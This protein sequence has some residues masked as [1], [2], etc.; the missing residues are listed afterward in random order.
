MA[1]RALPREESLTVLR[2]ADRRFGHGD[3]AEIAEIGDD[4]QDVV[5]RHVQALRR[6]LRARHALA[7]GVEQPLVGGAAGDERDQIRTAIAAGIESVAVAAG[8]PVRRHAAA[9]RFLVSEVRVVGGRMRT[10]L[11]RDEQ[12]ARHETQRSEHCRT[13]E[14]HRSLLGYAFTICGIRVP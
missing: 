14:G 6:H 12:T 10:L 3:A 2:V 11:L 1:G 5:V 13:R 7:D 4:L 9:N 8:H